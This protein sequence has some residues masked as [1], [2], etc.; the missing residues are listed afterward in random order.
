[1]HLGLLTPTGDIIASQMALVVKKKK[2]NT[3]ANA[4]DFRDAV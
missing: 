1:M 3:P 4:G 2:K